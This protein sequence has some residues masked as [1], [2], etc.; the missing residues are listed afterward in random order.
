MGDINPSKMPKGKRIVRKDDPN[1]VTMY[2]EGGQVWDKP[3]PK[4]LGA[5]KPMSAGKKSKAKAMAKAAGR[6][7]PNLV[8][9]MR[10]AK[11]K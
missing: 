5:P 2:A 1:D 4:K 10:A 11:G 7:Y 6:P 9:N 3:R 8:D